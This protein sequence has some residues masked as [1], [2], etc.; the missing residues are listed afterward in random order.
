MEYQKYNVWNFS[1]FVVLAMGL[2]LIVLS[3]FLTIGPLEQTDGTSEQI[4]ATFLAVFG[5]VAIG[6]QLTIA[7]VIN[8]C[9][10]AF[11]EKG[12]QGY[13]PANQV[14]L[15]QWFRKHF[16]GKSITR[17]FSLN[18][19]ELNGVLY[20]EGSKKQFSKDEL[21]ELADLVRNESAN[22]KITAIDKDNVSAEFSNKPILHIMQIV[23]GIIS[24]K[25]MPL[26]HMVKRGI[27]IISIKLDRPSES[28]DVVVD[29]ERKNDE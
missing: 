23:D 12:R 26:D 25:E 1:G 6:F 7:A 5:G 16:E 8:R 11:F 29:M 3:A 15:C 19:Q 21:G 4:F 22:I 2:L 9:A 17:D 24:F 28:I 13:M 10:K 18:L 20:V 27:G 14:I